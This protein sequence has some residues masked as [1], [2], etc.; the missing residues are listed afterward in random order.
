MCWIIKSTD[1]HPE[2]VIFIVFPPQQLLHERA[3]MLHYTYIAC[4]VIGLKLVS[5]LFPLIQTLMK[6][7]NIHIAECAHLL[8]KHQD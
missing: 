3:S 8:C 7:T 6:P 2:Y 5:D 1:T 4:L